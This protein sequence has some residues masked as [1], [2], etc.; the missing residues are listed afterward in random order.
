[1]PTVVADASPLIFLAKVD[2]LDLVQRL[3]GGEILVPR[4]VHDEL[5]GPLVSPVEERRLSAFLERC[6]VVTVRRPRIF[7]RSLSDADNRVLTLALRMRADWILA[8]DHLL[9][10]V[11]RMEGLAAIGTLGI[12]LR[13]A[14][15]DLITAEQARRIIDTLIQKHGV[16]VSI[17]VYRQVAEALTALS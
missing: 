16:R 5:F 14:G 3:L 11:A 15:R 6:K 10:Q 9:R 8:D 4:A 12:L 1:M 7:A 13:S 2:Q 17:E